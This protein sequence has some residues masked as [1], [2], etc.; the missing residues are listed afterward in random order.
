V[1]S[2]NDSFIELENLLE[3]KFSLKEVLIVEA[4]SK[5]SDKIIKKQAGSA[6]ATYLRRTVSK[7]NIV[8]VTWGTTLQAMVDAMPTK[9]IE[10]IHIVQALGA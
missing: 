10:D 3:K 4:E 8:G 6:A 9:P 1:V 2:P 5:S 7:G